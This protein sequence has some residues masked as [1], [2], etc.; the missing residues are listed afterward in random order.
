M[1]YQQLAKILAS[2][3]A[4]PASAAGAVACAP[5]P[6]PYT[7]VVRSTDVSLD[8]QAACEAAVEIDQNTQPLSGFP[9]ALC[10][11]LCKDQE[12]NSCD[13]D[14]TYRQKFY[15]AN[16]SFSEPAT[17][18]AGAAASCPSLSATL[19]CAVIE[20]RGELHAG[21]P[22][23]GR[24]PAGL[25]DVVASG[26]GIGAY[27]AASAHLEAA[28]I[29]AFH[30]LHSELAALDAPPDLLDDIQCAAADEVR[31]AATMT[32][33]AA[34]YG[35]RAP[36]LEVAPP[37]S[38]PVLAIAA[39]NAVEGVVREAFGAALALFQAEHA[40]DLEI[41]DAMRAIAR[42]ECAHAAIAFRVAAFLDAQLD[43][44]ERAAVEASKREAIDELLA[45]LE[46]PSV[47]LAHA[48]RLPSVADA[49]WILDGMR[50]EL[51]D[52]ARAA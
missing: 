12:V 45:S 20:Q 39:E 8:A 18:G 1:T 25:A 36:E 41:R 37:A 33:L 29:V 35:A 38:R 22:I 52:A 19:T 50:A 48:A 2:L 43:T 5:P 10:T 27:L 30:A 47:A 21:C 14:A 32:R 3:V 44:T 49:A 16:P 17:G 46:E 13:L 7:E 34:R 31:H 11:K 4:L 26:T 40:A 9:D 24:R 23:A 15:E 51:W 6:C 42:D 28:S